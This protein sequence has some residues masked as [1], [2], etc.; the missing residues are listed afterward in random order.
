MIDVH[1]FSTFEAWMNSTNNLKNEI[2]ELDDYHRILFTKATIEI[3]NG[4]YNEVTN[5]KDITLS[6]I[7][8]AYELKKNA[9]GV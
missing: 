7:M 3:M 8:K 5:K 6:D 1:S 9:A 4:F 2:K